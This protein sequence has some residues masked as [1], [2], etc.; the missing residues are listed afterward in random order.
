[1]NSQTQF[2]EITFSSF[3]IMLFLHAIYC[4]EHPFYI[5]LDTLRTFTSLL[6]ICTYAERF[7]FT[8]EQNAP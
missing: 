1:M 2:L 4:S 6:Y 8:P 7:N 3:L 5:V